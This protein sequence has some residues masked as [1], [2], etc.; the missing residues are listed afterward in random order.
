MARADHLLCTLSE[1]YV[2]KIIFLKKINSKKMLH[3]IFTLKTSKLTQSCQ[4][5][6]LING[7]NSLTKKKQKLG[8]IFEKK[9]LHMRKSS[10]WISSNGYRTILHSNFMKQKKTFF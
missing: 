8:V 3:E 1:I 7:Q 10:I 9:F 6:A 5:Y 4:K 2:E